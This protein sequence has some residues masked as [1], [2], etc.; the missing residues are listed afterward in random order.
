MT[1][2]PPAHYS[3]LTT[4]SANGG[5]RSAF[6]L[7]ETAL[8]MLAI[9]LGLLALIGLGRLGLQTNKETLN[10]HRCAAL[11]AAIFETLR[12]RNAFF[13]DLA[14]TNEFYTSWHEIWD[15]A[16]DKKEIAFPQIAYIT[17]PV[18]NLVFGAIIPAYAPDHISLADWNPRYGLSLHGDDYHSPVAQ[19][20]NLLHCT[21]YIYPDGNTH[22][23]DMRIYTT[24]LTNP[25]GL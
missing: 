25:G 22:S 11:S 24:T 6:T 3:L 8:A 23:S 17:S 10:D 15:D 20:I 19:A 13:V 14:R 4:H 7:V 18:S 2:S 9:G 1:V 5:R 16:I 21:L 12:E